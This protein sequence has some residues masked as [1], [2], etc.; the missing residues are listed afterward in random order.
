[1]VER[2][3]N[4]RFI[5]GSG[6]KDISGNRY[7]K[8]VA[9]RFHH[10][11]NHKS[12]WVCRCD[13]GNEKVIRSDCLTRIQS[14]GCVKKEQDVKNLHIINQHG[15]YNHPAYRIWCGMMARCFN[16]H[17]E[18]YKDY[19]GRGITVCN[20]WQDAKT[21]CDWMVS[22]GYRKGLSIER[23]YVNGNYEPSNC[24]L[25]PCS[26]QA[27]NKRNTVYAMTDKGVIAVAKEARKNGIYYK[28]AYY[29][30]KHGEW[31]YDRIFYNG[32]LEDYKNG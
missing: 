24:T 2:D 1:M 23:I 6:F 30:I 26:E 11:Q 8:L 19:G 7:G 4:G 17:N 20:E 9:I 13:C 5:K 25:I 21:F 3:N 10:S 31:E 18:A 27:Y 14:C 16:P 15:Y 22:N 32:R 29:R 12:Y 28:T